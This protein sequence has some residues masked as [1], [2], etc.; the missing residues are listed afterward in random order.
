MPAIPTTHDVPPG[1]CTCT[2]MLRAASSLLIS[3]RASARQMRGGAR[4]GIGGGPP[5]WKS[6][7]SA[8]TCGRP[9][10]SRHT[11]SCYLSSCSNAATATAASH[12]TAAV[13][14]TA[15]AA[16]FASNCSLNSNSNSYSSSSSKS[17][18]S[19]FS[20]NR[21]SCCSML[22]ARSIQGGSSRSSRGQHG[23][24]TSLSP[25][26]STIYSASHLTTFQSSLLFHNSMATVT[27]PSPDQT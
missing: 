6:G 20:S 4:E 5:V 13:A 21:S 7:S 27:Y 18:R 2:C 24:N 15:A 22:D 23:A 1:P 26:L 14:I 17:S 12:Q 25:P 8:K 16:F 3:R 11:C 19:S 10:P 9:C